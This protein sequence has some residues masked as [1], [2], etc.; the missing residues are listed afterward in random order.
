MVNR[1]NSTPFRWSGVRVS[2]RLASVPRSAVGSAPSVS[3]TRAARAPSPCL[4]APAARHAFAPV[5]DQPLLDPGERLVEVAF[6]PAVH[7]RLDLLGVLER[8]PGGHARR[9]GVLAHGR[10]DAQHAHGVSRAAVGV[11]LARL[12]HPRH[13]PERIGAERI[14]VDAEV[15]FGR[16]HPLRDVRVELFEGHRRFISP[17]SSTSRAKAWMRAFS[18][19]RRQLT[20]SSSQ[21]HDTASWPEILTKYISVFPPFSL[22]LY[23][24]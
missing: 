5:R 21:I 4:S 2:D 9:P 1:S 23:P 10:H 11:H 8:G 18:S 20:N 19:S 12:D 24:R 13:A 22:R 17:P 7:H 15:P 3:P 16:G 14:P 6:C